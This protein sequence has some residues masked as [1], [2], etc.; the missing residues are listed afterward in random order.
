MN[1][2]DLL[3]TATLVALSAVA[4]S[5]LAADEH[6]H[7]HAGAAKFKPAQDAA[8][9]CIAKGEQ[10]LAHCLMLLG[11]GDK[12]MA[13]CAKTVNQMLATCTALQKLAAQQSSMT[14]AMAKVALDACSECEKECRKHEKKH[15]E[16]KACAESCAECGKQCKAI[17]A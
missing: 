1:R 13:E 3:Q 5:T 8:G 15:A 14:P 6:A 7:H 17:A 12:S 9:V 11:D 10:C 2:R 4:T 16:C